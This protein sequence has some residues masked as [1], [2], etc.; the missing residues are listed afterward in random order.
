MVTTPSG[1]EVAVAVPEGVAPGEDFEV[2]VGSGAE[3]AAQPVGEGGA[4]PPKPVRPAP[5][6]PMRRATRMVVH[7]TSYSRC[8]GMR[9]GSAA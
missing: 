6:A 8:G 5:V 4:A 3:V 9:P 7:A 2:D 1:A